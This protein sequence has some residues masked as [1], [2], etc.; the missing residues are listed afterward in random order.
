MRTFNTADWIENFRVSKETFFYMCEKLRPVIQRQNTRMRTAIGV[1]QRLAITLWC[2]ATCSE[3]R[4]IG[5]LFGVARCTV[6][7]IVHDTCDAIVRVFLSAFIK[8]PTGDELKEVIDGFNSKWEMVQCAGAIDGSHIPVKPPALHHTDYYNRKGWYSVILQAV[9]DH[10]YMFT[11]VVVGWPGSVHDSRVLA[12]SQL[13]QKASN[14]QILQSCS[15]TVMGREIMPFL[16]GDSAYPLKT[17]LLKPFACNSTLSNEQK[18]FNYHLSRA[19]IVV[20]N[21]YGR[22]KGRWRRLIKQNEMDISRVPQ[23]ITACCILH[24][25]CEVHG[26]A[27]AETWL[28]GPDLMQPNPV[29]AP[30]AACSQAKQIRDILVQYY[31]TL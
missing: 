13:Y 6:C 22:L 17:W 28:E 21:A 27:F 7:V 19:R 23:V 2:L 3:Y 26:D 9:V 12:H 1:E 18:T 25:I 29:T 10:N 4:T 8:F 20:E 15:R 16:I 24:N 30:Q 5:H 14:K 11:D 31:T